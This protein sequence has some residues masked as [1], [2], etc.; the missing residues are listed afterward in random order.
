MHSKKVGAIS[1]RWEGEKAGFITFFWRLWS[2]PAQSE[3]SAQV[4]SR[5]RSC[6][7]TLGEENAFAE[8][9]SELASDVLR[10]GKIVSVAEDMAQGDRIREEQAVLLSSQQ[11]ATRQLPPSRSPNDVPEPTAKTPVYL[12]TPPYFS[13]HCVW[14]RPGG[15]LTMEGRLP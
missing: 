3:I 10:L 4:L 5:V 13:D 1:R 11:K 6:E 2:S 7:L 14:R 9:P 12:T 15:S 8:N